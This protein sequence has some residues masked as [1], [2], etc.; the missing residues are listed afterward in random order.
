MGVEL[1]ELAGKGTDTL[2]LASILLEKFGLGALDVRR[3]IA[4]LTRP[5]RKNL[6]RR[7]V[8]QPNLL[9]LL[10]RGLTLLYLISRLLKRFERI[11]DVLRCLGRHAQVLSEAPHLLM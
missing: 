10:A 9:V 6:H 11:T 4:H 5:L 1:L 3:N 7:F 2:S 8:E